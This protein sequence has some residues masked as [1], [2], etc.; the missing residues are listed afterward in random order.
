MAKP[1][2]SEA[3]DLAASLRTKK[4]SAG[5]LDKIEVDP[6][7]VEDPAAAKIV[8]FAIKR[9]KNLLIVGPTGCGKSCLAINVMAR[10]KERAEIFSCDGNT[11]TEELIGKPWAT[12][13]DKGVGITIPLYGAGVRAYRNGKI[14]LLE[15][16]DHAEPDIHASLHRIM[17]VNQGFYV[18]NVGKEEIIPKH[19]DFAVI[20]TANTIGS[21]EDI[22]LY[23]GTKVL[24]QAFMNRFSFT[25]TMDYLEPDQEKEVVKNKTG[26]PEKLADQIVWVANDVRDAANPKRIADVPGSAKIAATISTRDCIEWAEITL[27]LS[28]TP[29]EAAEYAFLNRISDVDAD[30]IRTFIS[31]R[32]A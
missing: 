10:L 6:F 11:S 29:K 4:G 24:N 31:N 18:C 15:E 2:I 21:G 1:T 14:L 7:F 3:Q 17:E 9:R 32:I 12:T 30:Q 19:K 27:G 20:A 25:V 28:M 23:T 8:E 16:I 13:D 5:E 22:F 26:A